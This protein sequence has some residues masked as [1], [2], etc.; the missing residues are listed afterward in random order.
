MPYTRKKQ[1]LMKLTALTERQRS[2]EAHRYSLVRAARAHN[3]DR[4][5]LC[6][7]AEIADAL[8]VTRQAAQQRYGKV[9][10]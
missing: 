3:L 6:T 2:I 8:G 5:P 9:D 7:W 4:Q 1:T 10:G